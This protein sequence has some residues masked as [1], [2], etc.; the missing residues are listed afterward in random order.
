MHPAEKTNM[1]FD[2]GLR[3]GSNL[4]SVRADK[5]RLGWGGGESWRWPARLLS[6]IQ[7]AASY[8][9]SP[10]LLPLQEQSQRTNERVGGQAADL[11]VF[12]LAFLST[13][14]L[15]PS[16]FVPLGSFLG[17]ARPGRQV[18]SPGTSLP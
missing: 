4:Y 5:R 3:K 11:A 18:N 10:P 6:L 15:I 13:C 14:S 12:L 1:I 8:P 9:P 7:G 16:P 2:S 17:C